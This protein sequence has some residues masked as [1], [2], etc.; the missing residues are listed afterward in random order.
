M[1]V[2]NRY[3]TKKICLKHL[4]AHCFW[5]LYKN[6]KAKGEKI[7]PKSTLGKIFLVNAY[8]EKYL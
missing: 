5:P 6:K 1:K 7:H 3:C 8:C 4:L 2:C